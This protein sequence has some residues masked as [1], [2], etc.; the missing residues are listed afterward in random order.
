M[1]TRSLQGE[2]L[3]IDSAYLSPESPRCVLAITQGF[4]VPRGSRAAQFN[5]VFC[6]TSFRSFNSRRIVVCC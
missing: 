2:E 1:A 4:T 5:T 3:S 6:A